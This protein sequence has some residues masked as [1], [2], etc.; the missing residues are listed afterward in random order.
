MAASCLVVVGWSVAVH[1]AAACRRGRPVTRSIQQRRP[2][3]RSHGHR[4]AREPAPTS[5]ITTPI[6]AVKDVHKSFGRGHNRFDALKGVSFTIREGESIAIGVVMAMLA[7]SALS[8]ALSG[9][10]LADLPGLTLTAFEPI[11]IVFIDG[12]IHV[13]AA[14][15]PLSVRAYLIVEGGLRAQR[16]RR[17]RRA[18]FG[19]RWWDGLCPPSRTQP[20]RS[21][22]R[23]PVSAARV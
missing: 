10:L 12:W 11:A 16:S 18:W 19:T 20:R 7:G 2:I 6:I 21:P 4:F 5:L 8:S 15:P 22:L 1:K 17:D 13:H 14:S 23:H 9:S 3:P